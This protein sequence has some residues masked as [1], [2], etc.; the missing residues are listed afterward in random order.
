MTANDWA[1]KLGQQHGAQERAASQTSETT[2]QAATDADNAA[3]I[4][5]PR[6][7][8]AITRLVGEYN[9]G[10]GRQVIDIT[11]DGTA[12]SRPALI[13]SAGGDT[14]PKLTVTLEESAIY[15]RNSGPGSASGETQHRLGTDRTDDAIAAYVLQHWMAK[16]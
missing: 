6:I 9:N 11:S 15:A 13:L 4:R 3:L 1:S 7:V 5:W 14:A 8:E 12:S 2:R 10:A 16:L